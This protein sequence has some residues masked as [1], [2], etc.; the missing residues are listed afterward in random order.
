MIKLIKKTLV[1]GIIAGIFLLTPISAFAEEGLD[2][3][4]APRST[5]SATQGTDG[6]VPL[7]KFLEEN[8]KEITPKKPNINDQTETKKFELPDSDSGDLGEF[9]KGYKPLDAE[10]MATANQYLSGPMKWVSYGLSGVIIIL[11]GLIFLITALDLIYITV[12]FSRSFLYTPSTSGTGSPV[13]G[14]NQQSG[15]SSILGMQWVS[16]EAVKAAALIGGESATQGVHMQANPYGMGGPAMTPQQTRKQARGSVIGAYFRSRIMFMI[17]FG[18]SIILLTSS[19][20]LDFGI[21]VGGMIITVINNW[22]S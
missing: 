5:P 3:L 21:N 22:I 18:V 12:P 6:N 14:I 20:F 19:V 4:D 7:D 1:G 8:N 15:T 17:M 13:G 9:I 16:D 10:S 2:D 11:T